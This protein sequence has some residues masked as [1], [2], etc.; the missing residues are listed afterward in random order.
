MINDKGYWVGPRQGK[1]ICNIYPA[2]SGDLFGQENRKS[3]EMVLVIWNIFMVNLIAFNAFPIFLI[4]VSMGIE[5]HFKDTR[6]LTLFKQ[7]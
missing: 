2:A 5:M 4:I 6:I 7:V 1:E 3:S